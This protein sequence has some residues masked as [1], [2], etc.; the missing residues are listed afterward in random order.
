M[1]LVGTYCQPGILT[2]VSESRP[3]ASGVSTD[4]K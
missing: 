4:D 2:W 3:A 1:V